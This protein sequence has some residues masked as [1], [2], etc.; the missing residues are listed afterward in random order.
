M[1]RNLG[2][3]ERHARSLGNGEVGS[4]VRRNETFYAC[5]DGCVDEDGLTR[6][7]FES[8]D[9]DYSI[10]AFESGGNGV[11]GLIVGCNDFNC[12]RIG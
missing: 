2:C 6:Y 3:I 4:E 10:L 9:G 11:D 7:S 5:R 8:Y 12:L 1:D